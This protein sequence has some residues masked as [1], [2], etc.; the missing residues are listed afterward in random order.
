MNEQ[1][2]FQA[3]DR[4]D[5]RDWLEKHH[6]IQSFV[7]LVIRTASSPLQGVRYEEAVEEALCFGW[8]DSKA[9]RRNKESYLLYFAPRKPKSN[10]SRTNRLRAQKMIG[11]GKMTEAGMKAIELAR[12]TGAWVASDDAERARIPD[13]LQEAFERNKTA[14]ANFQAFP[15]STKGVILEWIRSA[16]RPETR[17]KRIEETVHLA[18]R[19]IRAPQWR[20]K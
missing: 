15:R 19:N 18:E 10:W 6:Q 17:R 2:Q 9:H 8:I 1:G 13:D 4:N 12:K 5:W 3:T 7:W 16:M 20:A 14:A 11:E